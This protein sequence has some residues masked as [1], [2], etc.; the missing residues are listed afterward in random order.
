[1]CPIPYLLLK[2]IKKTEEVV[3]LCNVDIIPANYVIK[4]INNRRRKYDNQLFDYEI[5][6]I[7]QLDPALIEISKYNG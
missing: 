3:L 4:N 1:M 6:L 7:M 2:G 5:P